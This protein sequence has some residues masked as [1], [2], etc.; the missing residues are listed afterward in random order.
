MRSLIAIILFAAVANAQVGKLGHQ[1]A[2]YGVT[3]PRQRANPVLSSQGFSARL[4]TWSAPQQQQR[5][6]SVASATE[7]EEARKWIDNWKAKQGGLAT[8]GDAA[9]AAPAGEGSD[10]K[11]NIYNSDTA[12]CGSGPACEYT[13]ENPD[14]CVSNVPYDQTKFWVA[15]PGKGAGEYTGNI[16]AAGEWKKVAKCESIWEVG[17]P[18]MI[19]GKRTQGSFLFPNI[20]WAT[21]AQSFAKRVKYG[22]VD[23]VVVCE[24]VPASVLDSSWSA[25]MYDNCEIS[26]KIRPFGP[27]G[28]RVETAD[29]NMKCQRFRNAIEKVCSKCAG[30]APSSGAGES[31]ASKCAAIGVSAAA[32]LAPDSNATGFGYVMLFS[33]T[34]FV[35]ALIGLS[36]VFRGF[37]KPAD[38]L[39]EPI[40]EA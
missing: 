22:F 1:K 5:F 26:Y 32:G 34:S 7:A 30:Q 38:G 9:A 29:T 4:P 12:S 36:K 31:L 2:P 23:D 11:V 35:L 6:S 28:G 16:D 17:S 20:D 37:R 24:S 3:V 8:T 27:G 10:P 21:W 15:M 25:E 19:F 14:I 13:S 33:L 40:L 39:Q 18:S